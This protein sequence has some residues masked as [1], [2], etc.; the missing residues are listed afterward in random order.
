MKVVTGEALNALIDRFKKYAETA[1]QSE[2]V[3]LA[4][5]Q[6]MIEKT[7]V[8][9]IIKNQKEARSMYRVIARVIFEDCTEYEEVKQ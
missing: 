6:M 2:F 8:K 4:I 7:D 3:R 5:V 9:E 1:E